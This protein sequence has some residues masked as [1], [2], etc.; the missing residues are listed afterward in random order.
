MEC[1]H[2]LSQSPQNVLAQRMC[3][4]VKTKHNCKASVVSAVFILAITII[5]YEYTSINVKD[6]YL[7]RSQWLGRVT[8][9]SYH[10]LLHSV[11]SLLF[12]LQQ[13]RI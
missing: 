1:V 3:H 9:K 5:C 12:S 11:S 10:R 4:F 13:Q 7:T 2:R 6:I 8:D